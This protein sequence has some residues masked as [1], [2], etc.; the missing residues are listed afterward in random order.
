MKMILKILRGYAIK[1]IKGFLIM[2]FAIAISTT[3]IFG[4]TVARVSQSKYVSDEVYRQSPSYQVGAFDLEKSDFDK[5]VKDDNVKN[6]VSMRYY[7]IFDNKGK[8]YRVEEFNKISF[9]KLKH[10]LISG[11]FPEEKDEIIISD[12]LFSDLKS[13]GKL[14]PPNGNTGNNEYKVNLNYSK[15]YVNDL[16]E[17][18][19]FNQMQEFKIAGIYKTTDIMKKFSVGIY[20]SKKFEYP[21]EITTYNGLIDLKTGFKDVPN[22]M[23]KLASKT[24]SGLRGLYTNSELSLAQQDNMVAS[25][26]FDLFNKG[27]I[28]ASICI[29]FNVFNIMMKEFIKEIGLLRVVGMSKKQSL[30]FFISKNLLVLTL[31]LFLGFAGGHLLAVIMINNM[32]LSSTLLDVSKAPIYISKPT[33]IKTLRVIISIVIISTIIPIIITLKSYPRDMMSGKFNSNALDELLSKIKLYR[34]IKLLI[35][36]LLEKIKNKFKNKNKNK[37]INLNLSMSAKLAISNSKRN[38]VYI[39]TTAIISGMAGLYGAQQFIVQNKETDD[40]GSSMV[41]SMADYD[42]ELN[43][44]GYNR[45]NDVGISSN[46]LDKILDI[47]GITDNYTYN[48]TDASI[49]QNINDLSENYKTALSLKNEDKEKDMDFEFIGLNKEALYHLN[50]EY[51]GTIESGRVYE[52]NDEIIEAVVNNNFSFNGTQGEFNE[53]LKLGDILDCRVLIENDG[54]L[55]YKT[56]KIKIVGFLSKQWSTRNG[57]TNIVTPDILVDSSEYEKITVNS[58]YSKVK[59]KCEKSKLEEVKNKVQDIIKNKPDIEYK[60]RSTIKE[61]SGIFRWQVILRDASNSIMLI[62]TASINII[63]SIIASILMRKR[64]FGVMRSVGLSIH[65]LKKILIYEGLIY[66][67]VS[68]FT[69]ILFILISGAKWTHL[70]RTISKL[71]GIPYTGPIVVFPALPTIVFVLITIA[72]SLMSTVFTFKNLTKDSIVDQ[73]KE[74]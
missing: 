73:L 54:K 35:I 70:M 17:R 49:K 6:Y 47:K 42:I 59:I 22:Q 69:G 63:F 55:E 38:S 21:Q 56:I 39:L 1:N 58:N 41:Q 40:I 14:I 46:D 37:K 33:V 52:K 16:G 13:K 11:R 50:N 65:D 20:T 8:E 48:I 2:I 29:I 27:T 72:V 68:S 9:K 43:Y 25:S 31:G 12:I 26:N 3:I 61:E 32:H 62:I 60:D 74:D 24:D 10:T 64:E 34:K 66:G 71:Q 30:L 7:G 36:N 15:E 18:K 19:I 45:S 57:K 5:I 67:L 51:K 44:T 23:S 4:T 53:K 28:I